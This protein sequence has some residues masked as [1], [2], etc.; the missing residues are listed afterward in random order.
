[1]LKN[2]QIP[3]LT[4]DPK[5]LSEFASWIY[6]RRASLSMN[7]NVRYNHIQL[8]ARELLQMLKDEYNLNE[9]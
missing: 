9:D 4:Y 6:M 2:I 7:V 1:M 8:K 3:L 5:I